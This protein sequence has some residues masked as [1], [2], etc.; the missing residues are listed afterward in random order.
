M[1]LSWMLS[2][3]LSVTVEMTLKKK[4]WQDIPG[5]STWNFLTFCYLARQDL[6]TRCALFFWQCYISSC[7]Q[8]H[9]LTYV[10]HQSVKI[11]VLWLLTTVVALKLEVR[12]NARSP[13]PES[14]AVLFF[15]FCIF[16][17][18]LYNCWHTFGPEKGLLKDLY[19]VFQADRALQ[20][21]LKG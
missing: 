19:A 5:A 16:F 2:V 9:M 20:K 6:G 8:F 15:F 21:V 10:K 13:K 11:T 17:K 4:P 7:V 18:K 3:Y 12:G 14:H 1:C